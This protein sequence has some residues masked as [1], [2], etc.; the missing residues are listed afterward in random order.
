MIHTSEVNSIIDEI[1]SEIPLASLNAVLAAVEAEI[2]IDSLDIPESQEE[3]IDLVHELEQNQSI[4][5]ITEDLHVPIETIISQTDTSII[6]PSGELVE[7]RVEQ[8]TEE[9]FSAPAGTIA[10]G[11]ET[12][13]PTIQQEIEQI[14]ET[15]TETPQ[16]DPGLVETVVN[17]VE[18]TAPTTEA[19]TTTVVE[20]TPPP[21]TI[22]V[23]AL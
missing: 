9:I 13:P 22:S 17:T 14:Q 8:I 18:Q 4:E 12:L 2:F 15:T 5:I 1:R 21:S 7:E 11:E 10:P 16:I 20:E 3:V 6:E 19:S 23:P